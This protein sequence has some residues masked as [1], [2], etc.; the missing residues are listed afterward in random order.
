MNEETLYKGNRI[1]GD[2]MY[3]ER[4]VKWLKGLREDII[5]GKDSRSEKDV[6]KR[7]LE[8]FHDTD[9]SCWAVALRG[10]IIKSIL[11]SIDE[12]LA[13]L[14]K[15]LITLNEELDRL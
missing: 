15:E 13:S 10:R 2:I 4:D 8:S 7:V 3:C 14:D 11:D 6:I 1:K 9:T 5:S 12:R